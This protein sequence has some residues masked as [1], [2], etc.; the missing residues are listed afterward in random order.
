MSE[1]NKVTILCLLNEDIECSRRG[2]QGRCDLN[3]VAP[4]AKC[5]YMI[6]TIPLREP[7]KDIENKTA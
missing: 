6:Q 3:K 1:S 5:E 2:Y 4:Y 7:P